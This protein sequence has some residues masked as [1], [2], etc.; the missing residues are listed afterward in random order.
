MLGS[1][2]SPEK[3]SVVVV[4][5]ET[6]SR[7]RLLD[8]FK[9]QTDFEIAGVGRSG[10]EAVQLIRNASPDLVFLNA[11]MAGMDGFAV[12]EEVG[13]QHAPLVVLVSSNDKDA[14]HAFEAHALDYILKP[15]SDERF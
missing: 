6:A 10:P 3:I 5:D 13:S 12:L 9:K 4:D 7:A 8:L 15:F 14:I 11:Q 2:V 1:E